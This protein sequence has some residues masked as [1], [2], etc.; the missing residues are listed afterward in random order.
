MKHR[1]IKISRRK[2]KVRMAELYRTKC[3]Q[4]EQLNRKCRAQDTSIRLLRKVIDDAQEQR[5]A[6]E[7]EN[8]ELRSYIERLWFPK[9]PQ[10]KKGVER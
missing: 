2:R 3:E 9:S 7:I 10:N 5:N 1:K 6:L 8:R 4:I